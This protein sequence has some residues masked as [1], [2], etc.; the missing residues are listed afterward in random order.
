[1]SEDIP[2]LQAI[3]SKMIGRLD[4]ILPD[5]LSHTL[6]EERQWPF[7]QIYMKLDPVLAAL[8]KQYCDARAKLNRLQIEHGPTDPMTDVAFD[9]KDS[10]EAAVT[11]RL[12]ELQDDEDIQGQVAAEVAA[13]KS[14][15]RSPLVM[16]SN[17]EDEFDRA[18][19]FMIWAKLMMKTTKPRQDVRQHFRLAA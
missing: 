11:T 7:I 4:D 17:K 14:V 1:M 8:Y 9:M 18:L 12:L 10:A 3:M 5:Q 19:A 15:P 13:L 2:S 6:P 16:G